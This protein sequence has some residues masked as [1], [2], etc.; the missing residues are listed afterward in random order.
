M[1]MAAIRS[2]IEAR[3][4]QNFTALPKAFENVPFDKTGVSAFAEISIRPTTSHLT[5]LGTTSPMYRTHGIIRVNVYGAK[6]IG[7]K[8]VTEHA[9][10]VAS[11]FRDAEFSGIVC[12]T[13]TIHTV[14]DVDGW[15]AVSVIVEF[16]AD[17]NS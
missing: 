16:Y 11:I 1:S 3:F 14:G 9:D 5:C 10:G 17:Q 4:K 13:P 6:G 7:P 2:A 12:R 15:W 8:A